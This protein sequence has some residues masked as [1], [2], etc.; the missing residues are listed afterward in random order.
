M[1]HLNE[2]KI[3]RNKILLKVKKMI[4]EKKIKNEFRKPYKITV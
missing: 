2:K 4:P 3:Y 1:I